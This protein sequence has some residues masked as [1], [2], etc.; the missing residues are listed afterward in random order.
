MYRVELKVCPGV[1]FPTKGKVPNVPCGVERSPWDVGIAVMRPFLMYRVELKDMLILK[2]LL[3]YNMSVPN[4][5]CGVE[6]ALIPYM[7]NITATVPNVPCGVES[8]QPQVLLDVELKKK[9]SETA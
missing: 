1:S 4:V 5:P 9:L 2:A 8:Y 7:R 3:R 6:R